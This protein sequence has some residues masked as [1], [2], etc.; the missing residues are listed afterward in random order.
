MNYNEIKELASSKR[1]SIKELTERI[2]YTRQGLQNALDSE[3]IELRKLKLLCEVLRVSPSLFFDNG[4]FGVIMTNGGH[5]QVGNGNKISIESKDREIE[6][7]KQRLS[8]KDEIIRLLR[9]VNNKPKSGYI[10]AAEPE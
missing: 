8:D 5:T 1:I 7:L 10:T 6:L 4:T 3:T 2:G 9:D